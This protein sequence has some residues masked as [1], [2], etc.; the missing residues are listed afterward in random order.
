AEPAPAPAAQLD[1]RGTRRA[2]R[3]KVADGVEVFVDGNPATLVDVSVVGAQVVSP[4]IL[5]PNQR[6][7][8][9]LPDGGRLIRVSGGVAW[10]AFEMPK[11]G[12]QYRAG[13][14]FF[15]SDPAAIQRF[16]DANKR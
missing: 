8:L 10:A 13:I 11:G 12:P 9:S 7:R 2:L 4:T 15:D 1:Q 16:I 6:V 5:R 3:F 14:E